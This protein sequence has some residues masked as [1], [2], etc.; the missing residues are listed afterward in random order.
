NYLPSTVS[1][2]IEQCAYQLTLENAYSQD[3]LAKTASKL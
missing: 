2:H 3:R 1:T